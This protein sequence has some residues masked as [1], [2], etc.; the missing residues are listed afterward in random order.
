M[1]IGLTNLSTL[2][3][4]MDGHDH[5]GTSS[6]SAKTQCRPPHLS[7]RLLDVSWPH[8]HHLVHVQ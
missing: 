8:M 3:L 4:K 7:P 6:F 5:T 1:R 2:Q